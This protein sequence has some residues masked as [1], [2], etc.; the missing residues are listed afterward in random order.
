[1]TNDWVIDMILLSKISYKR[2]GVD[3]FGQIQPYIPFMAQDVS[4]SFEAVDEVTI[5]ATAVVGG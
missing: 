1:M 4:M 2:D 5:R 3:G